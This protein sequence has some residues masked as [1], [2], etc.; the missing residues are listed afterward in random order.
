MFC[1]IDFYFFCG[2]LVNKYMGRYKRPSTNMSLN[3]PTITK[4]GLEMT[5]KPVFVGIVRTHLRF[6]G[7]SLH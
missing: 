3:I 5:N 1:Y 6:D 2:K 7:E 4:M